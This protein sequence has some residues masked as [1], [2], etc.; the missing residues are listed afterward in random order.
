[1]EF[2][3]ENISHETGRFFEILGLRISDNS[4]REVSGGWDQP[5]VKEHNFDGGVLALLRTYIDDL[6]HT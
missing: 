2:S 3:D 4:G 5:I 1:M 6:P